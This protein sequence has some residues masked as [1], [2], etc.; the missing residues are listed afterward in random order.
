MGGDPPAPNHIDNMTPRVGGLRWHGPTTLRAVP[1]SLELLAV[2]RLCL[3][4]SA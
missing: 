1:P 4:S 3:R 2:A